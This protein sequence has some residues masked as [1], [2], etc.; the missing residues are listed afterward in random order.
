MNGDTESAI[1]TQHD[2]NYERLVELM[3]RTRVPR[4]AVGFLNY[5]YAP[6]T[7]W[8]KLSEWRWVLRPDRLFISLVLAILRD[9]D[10][11][12]RRLVD[13]GAGRG[14]TARFVSRHF[15]T[16]LYVAVDRI[17]VHARLVRERAAGVG[18]VCCIQADS[19]KLPIRSC[20]F[21]IAV[22]LESAH[23]Y[24]APDVFLHEVARLL[25]TGGTLVIADAFFADSF[26]DWLTL[27]RVSGFDIQASGDVTSNV[28]AARRRSGRLLRAVG[29]RAGCSSFLSNFAGLEGSPIYDLLSRRELVYRWVHAV[30]TDEHVG[31][32]MFDTSRAAVLSLRRRAVEFAM[33]IGAP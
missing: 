27:L 18:G 1:A 2:N 4:R 7:Q 33:L 17:M 28:V 12:G 5:G 32:A 25:C 22:C 8:R 31:D 10:L 15:D 20:S 3:D 19:Q 21:E 14:G 9:I 24:P 26:N 11:R 13:I 16:S 30:R 29:R 6:L 23:C